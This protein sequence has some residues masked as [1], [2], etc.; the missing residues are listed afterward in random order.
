MKGAPQYIFDIV[1]KCG[2]M[3]PLASGG[4]SCMVVSQSPVPGNR[5]GLDERDIRF[6]AARRAAG[7]TCGSPLGTY[8]SEVAVYAR[9]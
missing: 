5:L 3:A 2:A 8:T 6:S 1:N 9:H 7:Y 4:R